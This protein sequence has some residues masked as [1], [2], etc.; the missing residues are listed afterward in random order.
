MDNDKVFIAYTLSLIAG[1]A[2][3]LTIVVTAGKV[4]IPPLGFVVEHLALSL[5]FRSAY[6]SFDGSNWILSALELS[7]MIG[8]HESEDIAPAGSLPS[9]A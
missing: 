9:G 7:G 2:T 6:H 3:V 4:D 8:A 1:A 5:L